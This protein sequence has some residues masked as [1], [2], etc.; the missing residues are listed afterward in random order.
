MLLGLLL[1]ASMGLAACGPKTTAPSDPSPGTGAQT[2]TDPAVGGEI[3]LRLAK[4]PDNFNTILTGTVYGSMVTSQVY[5]SLF[6]FNEN[7]EPTPRIAKEWEASDD[8]LT[9]TIKIQEGIKFHNGDELTAEDV[10]WT[11][12][13][14]LHDDYKGPRKSSVSSVESFTASDKYTVVIQ[15][16]EPFAPLF[17]N[18]NYGIMSKKA[19][20]GVAIGE[21]DKAATTMKPIGS[22]PYK[23]VEYVRAQYVL[24]ERN[25]NWFF[26]EQNGGAPFI[27]SVH[28]KVIPDGDTALAALEAG[29]IDLDTPEG[30]DVASLRANYGD[31]LIPVD[32]NRRGWGY[33]QFNTVKFPL[34]DKKVRQALTYAVDRES[35]ITAVMD[36]NGVV[37]GGPLPPVS[38]AADPSLQPFPYD[39]KKAAQ[40]LEEAGW[41]KNSKGIYEKDGQPL[42]LTFYGSSGSGLIEGLTTIVRNNWTTLGV[43]VDVQLMDFNAMLENHVAPGKYD[44]TFSGFGLGLDPDSMYA[45]FHSSSGTPNEQGL[46]NGFNRMRYSNPDADKLLED[47]RREADVEKRKQIYSDFQKIFVD[48]APIALMYA[49]LYTDFHTA[50]LKGVVNYPGSG[51]S[52]DF[53]YRWYLNAK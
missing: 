38:W 31:K 24:L 28:F 35:I 49:N 6:E 19:F 44:V 37:P 45:L 50:R 52:Y 20:E 5:D 11:L 41:A 40:L 18:I 13:T 48:D 14:I 22:G 16:K 23:F 10:A 12:S 9:W 33:M 47:G 17:T 43:D 42:K 53:L 21:L 32:W 27:Q 7:Y 34:D 46:V 26:S 2:G 36:G 25:D 8:G 15:L 29:E 30:K 4:D 1:V 39:V 51:A 3:K